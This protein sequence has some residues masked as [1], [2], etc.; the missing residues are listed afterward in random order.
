MTV[1]NISRKAGP[2]NGDDATVIFAFTYKTFAAADVLVV[3]TNSAGVETVQVLTT[4]YSVSLNTDQNVSPGGTI[5]MVVAP[6]VGELLTLGSDMDETQPATIRNQGPFLPETLE[7]MVDR[8][9]ISVQQ[10]LEILS[11]TLKI[12]ISDDVSRVV[13]LPTET[14][15]ANKVLA[16]GANGDVGVT[17]FNSG[18]VPD[19]TE[20]LKGL[21]EIATAAEANA[22]VDIVRA[23]T[24]GRIPISSAT[25]KG[26]IEIATLAEM[27]TG[28]DAVRVATPQGV[29]QQTDLK[30]LLAGA[31]SQPFAV[32]TLAFP[33]TQVPSSDANTLDDYEE[34]LWTPVIADASSGGNLATMANTFGSYTKIGN[35][36][37]WQAKVI[38]SSLGSIGGGSALF[39][40]GLPFVSANPSAN[41]VASVFVGWASGLAI[42]AL[43]SLGGLHTPNTSF[44]TLQQWDGTAGT[45]NV[46][47][48]NWSADGGMYISGSYMT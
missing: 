17:S 20:V 47:G 36:V 29:K 37:F 39:L 13:E 38:T 18:D 44:I 31:T 45:N 4:D 26:L 19:A 16:F 12:P 2:F 14:L 41:A 46:T 3:L 25:Q 21:I 28:T 6:A 32:K 23:L 24:P 9:T 27:T 33:S 10:L 34:G 35:R 11:R 42:T 30:A 8:N 1:T 48:T 7:T 43:S 40:Q 22:L 15:R 5:T